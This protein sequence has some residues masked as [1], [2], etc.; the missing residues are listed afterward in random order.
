MRIA[1]FAAGALMLA[2]CVTSPVAELTPGAYTLSVDTYLAGASR[3]ALRDKAADQADKFCA[4]KVAH[5]INENGV[6]VTGLT[7]MGVTIVFR[8]VASDPQKS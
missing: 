6:G 4:P 8:C 5:L 7:A 2:G 1:V 3:S